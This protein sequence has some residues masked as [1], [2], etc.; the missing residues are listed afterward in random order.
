MIPPAPVDF[1]ARVID[2]V[3]LHIWQREAGGNALTFPYVT[4]PIETQAAAARAANGAAAVVNVVDITP[5]MH[6]KR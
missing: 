2:R 4:V 6:D 1:W 5:G 3:A